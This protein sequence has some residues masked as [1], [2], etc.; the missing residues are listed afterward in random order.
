MRKKYISCKIDTFLARFLQDLA[1][2]MH[3]LAR[4]CKTSCKILQESCKKCIN[5]AR[6][7][8]K[9]YQSINLPRILQE[10]YQSCKNL[11][12]NISFLQESCRK[13]INLATIL[14]EIN[15]FWKVNMS[16]KNLLWSEEY[17]ISEKFR[18]L[19]F[20]HTLTVD[21][22]VCFEYVKTWF[23]AL[24]LCE[25]SNALS[26]LAFL[27]IFVFYISGFWGRW[28]VFCVWYDMLSLML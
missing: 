2:I 6:L 13:Y 26:K 18:V 7:L 14:Q 8:Q 4:L 25:S 21:L 11:A 10:M 9:M 22:G 19:D 23:L 12:R 17:L 16:K 3:Y 28:A 15:Y 24:G 27:S 5:L 20:D 1:R